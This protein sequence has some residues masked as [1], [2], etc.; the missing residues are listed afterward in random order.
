MLGSRFDTCLDEKK[1]SKVKIRVSDVARKAR[2]QLHCRLAPETI[3]FEN[4]LTSFAT[5]VGTPRVSQFVTI[6]GINQ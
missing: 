4:F 1:V 2:G 6:G 3:S 5:N